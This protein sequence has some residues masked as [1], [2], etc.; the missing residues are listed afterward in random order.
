MERDDGLDSV[1]G[2]RRDHL[3]RPFTH[4]LGRLKDRPPRYRPGEKT[5]G[6]LEGPRRTEENR[7]VGVVSTGMHDAVTHR[8]VVH[9]LSILDPQRIHVRA[10][11]NGSTVGRERRPSEDPSAFEHDRGT[12]PTVEKSVCKITGGPELL[13]ARLGM[14]VEMTSNLDKLAGDRVE[15]GVNRLVPVEHPYRISSKEG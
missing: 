4:F 6:S 5:F 12:E 9:R 14:R 2:T 8:A 15:K 11:R 10:K 13:P 3:C 7:R 1:H